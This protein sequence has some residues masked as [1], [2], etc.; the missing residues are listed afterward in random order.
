MVSVSQ[1]QSLASIPDSL[2]V[3]KDSTHAYRIASSCGSPTGSMN[4][5]AA[6]PPSYAWLQT[7]GY[8]NPASYGKNGTVC[9]SF[10]PTGN[11]VTINSGVS[12][13]GCGSTSYG[14]FN[15]YT[16]SPA[17]VSQGTGLTFAVTPGQCY[18]WCMGYS[19][20]GAFCSFNDFCPYYQQ[21]TVLPIELLY[22]AGSNQDNTNVFQWKTATEI[23]NNYFTIE[24]S[25]D[26]I[27]WVEVTRVNGAGNSTTPNQYSYFLNKYENKLNYYRLK[28]TDFNGAYKYH[29][30]I[31]IDN[32]ITNSE[33][34][35][36]GIYNQYGQ[37]VDENYK[38]FV[39][40][41]YEDG[42]SKKIIKE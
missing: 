23:N 35:I 13:S 6:P 3:D 7:N 38:G 33:P 42:T 21:S 28:Q 32:T 17:C 22:F 29:G 27:N 14:P 19:G 9:W 4:T 1:V 36:I 20:T 8:C 40:Y 12:S 11:T 18:T 25:L 30:I 37:Q 31:V 41:H 34:N 10:T 2:M 5:I 39:I 24:N 15:L 26:G 16:C